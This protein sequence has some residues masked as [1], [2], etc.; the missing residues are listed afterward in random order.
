MQ[1]SDGRAKSI[2]ERSIKMK[3][4]KVNSLLRWMKMFVRLHFF[5][6]TELFLQTRPVKLYTEV[7]FTP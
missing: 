7:V 4:F 5:A 1:T 6:N 3:N 2:D